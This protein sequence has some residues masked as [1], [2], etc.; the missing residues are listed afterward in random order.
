MLMRFSLTK[1]SL[2]CLYV[3]RIVAPTC[4][5]DGSGEGHLCVPDDVLCNSELE[6][7][8]LSNNRIGELPPEIGNL[9]KLKRLNLKNN[10]LSTL[11]L[12]IGKLEASETLLLSEN[13][14]ESLP[15]TIGNLKQLRYLDISRNM[16]TSLP[17]SIR[18]LSKLQYLDVRKNPLVETGV[19]GLTLGL[20]DLKEIFGDKI[21][22]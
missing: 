17:N 21:K 3:L 16:L 19:E 12:E 8:G 18:E 9:V 1:I 13:Y 14:I 5:Y 15:S 11:P 22:F 7:V 10:N 4:F 6:V 2:I 20:N